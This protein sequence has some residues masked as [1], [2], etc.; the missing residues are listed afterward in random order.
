VAEVVHRVE[1]R[2][3][4]V[5]DYARQETQRVVALLAGGCSVPLAL[6]AAAR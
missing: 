6:D 3:G 5:D 4:V 1:L 2:L